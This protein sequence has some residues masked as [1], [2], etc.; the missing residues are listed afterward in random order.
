VDEREAW[1]KLKAARVGHLATSGPDGIPH[2]VP[3]VFAVEGRTIYW[4]VDA[5]AKRSRELK[6]LANIRANPNVDLVVDN[7]EEDWQNLWWIRAHGTARI[8][9]PGNEWDMGLRL[10]TGKYQ[11]YQTDPPKGPV[12]AIDV[13]KLMSWE[14]V[15]G[16]QQPPDD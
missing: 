7:Y 15:P 2:V 1:E 14:A 13:L 16:S 5:K 10:L 12:V 6:R 8:L 9:E 3:F 4:A 11:R